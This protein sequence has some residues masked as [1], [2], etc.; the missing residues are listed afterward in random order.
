MSR[1][2]QILDRLIGFDTVSAKSNLALVDYVQAFL[3]NL[4]FTVHRLASP[5]G[6]KAGL[7][8]SLGPAGKGV[9]LSA[10]SDVV[11]VD[12]QSWSRDPFRLT[13]DR[14]RAYGRG[15][16]DM[17]GYLACV[18]AL[19]ER[20]AGVAL[21]EPLKIALSY[22]EEV[23]CVGVQHMSGD[24]ER[25]IGLPRAC[26]VG[27]PTEM[28][29]AIGHKGKGS[30]SAVC[31]GQSGHSALAPRFLNALH[32]AGDFL[33]ELRKIQDTLAMV[34]AQDSAYDIPYSTVHV[35]RM[36][37]GE[38][39]NIVPVRAEIL[40]EYRH[41][42]ADDPKGILSRIQDSAQMVR[43]AHRLRFETADIEIHPINSYPGLEIS[44]KAEVTR[45]VQGLVHSDQTI[46]VAFGTEAGVFAGLGIPTVVC[47]P[48]SMTG[49]GH[50]ADEFIAVAQLAECDRMMDRLLA[51]LTG[52]VPA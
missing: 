2:L 8:A 38:A 25:S 35:G 15:T 37:G 14:D 26:I 17:K 1:T 32:V 45:L 5:C 47:G 13:L 12:G 27:E 46:K 30:L 29:V 24:L 4:G 52:R 34:G 21:A 44:P 11:P 31:H 9:L 6:Q 10:H 39:L 48:G 41:L 7:F 51:E 49:Q 22:D 3:S 42:P 40:F 36:R 16:T 50:K 20:A 18:L 28:Q 19:A 33:A 43:A 23:G